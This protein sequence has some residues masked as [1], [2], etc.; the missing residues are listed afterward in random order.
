MRRRRIAMT[1]FRKRLAKKL[2]TLRGE[3]SQHRY[4]KEVGVSK[5]TLSRLEAGEQNIT[6]DSLEILCSK[7]GCDIVDLFAEEGGRRKG[8]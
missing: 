7:L 1:N 3:K 4:S 8:R 2:I 6:L 5:S